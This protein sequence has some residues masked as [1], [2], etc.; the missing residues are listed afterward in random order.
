MKNN[1]KKKFPGNIKFPLPDGVD[2][3]NL[4]LDLKLRRQAVLKQAQMIVDQAED[5]GEEVIEALGGFLL[6]S[7][8]N[9]KRRDRVEIY[10]E[11]ILMLLGMT[12]G[13]VE[14]TQQSSDSL[15]DD[16]VFAHSVNRA[17]RHN[18]LKMFR[19]GQKATFQKVQSPQQPRNQMEKKAEQRIGG[20]LLPFPTNR[21]AFERS[22]D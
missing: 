12:A 11:I 10:P 2:E 9:V 8:F 4:P 22:D 13:Y 17:T 6:E 21:T 16:P 3:N 1:D 14:A 18:L 15:K 20:K 19:V 5:L 7:G